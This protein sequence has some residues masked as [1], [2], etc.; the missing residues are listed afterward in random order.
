MYL[1]RLSLNF[2]VRKLG[3]NW[4]RKLGSQEVRLQ[5]RVC[6]SAE[7]AKNFWLSWPWLS[8]F[9]GWGSLNMTFTS[10]F[11][12]IYIYIVSLWK[13]NGFTYSI[14]VPG[15]W[16]RNGWSCVE[17]TKGEIYKYS[18]NENAITLTS[19]TMDVANRIC[20]W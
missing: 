15:L 19:K 14:K 8:L 9:R 3:F 10:K 18:K 11:L 4:L 7:G 12:Y 13:I 6:L 5:L 2:L 1:L 16:W 20:N 17:I